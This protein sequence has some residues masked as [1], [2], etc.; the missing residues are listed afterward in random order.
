MT[1]VSMFCRKGH[2]H[3]A[4][5]DFYP[6][7]IMAKLKDLPIVR[8]RI[9]SV[10]QDPHCIR[11]PRGIP[12]SQSH[13]ALAAQWDWERNF[14]K[15]SDVTPG[16]DRE[17]H[18]IHDRCGQR[19][20]AAINSRVR[21]WD[22]GSA[23]QGCYICVGKTRGRSNKILKIPPWL[24]E[25]AVH[26]PRKLLACHLPA[27][28]LA[29]RLWKCPDENCGHIYCSRVCDRLDPESP[30]ERQGCP[31]EYHWKGGVDLRR[32]PDFLEMFVKTSINR[33][34]DP[35]RFPAQCKVRWQGKVCGH[36]FSAAFETVYEA[37]GC[38]T[39]L[40]RKKQAGF[41]VSDSRL[42]REFVRVPNFP[43]LT[44]ANI[45]RGSD[46]VAVWRG[47]CGHTFHYAIFRRTTDKQ[48][49]NICSGHRSE[50]DKFFSVYPRL[51]KFWDY[52]KNTFI[53]A[54]TGE[55]KPLEPDLIMA[56]E[57]K[58]HWLL[59]KRSGHS[60]RASLLDLLMKETACPKC[61]TLPNCV[62]V[63]APKLID[64]WCQRLN[65]DQTPWNKAAGSNEEVWWACPVHKSHVWEAQVK[66]RVHQSTGCPYCANRKVSVTN[67]LATKHPKIARHFHPEKNVDGQ[68]VLKAAEI[69]AATKKPIWWL[70][71][72]RESYQRFIK[73]MVD[74]GPGC[75][76]CKN[77]DRALAQASTK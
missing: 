59:C 62:A 27:R 64:Q 53:D 24:A 55:E 28:S 12:L 38:V 20:T 70:C 44:P 37:G 60:Y 35:H 23:N 30:T 48:N 77:S 66:K 54:T 50:G 22:E 72:C 34:F 10:G 16:S 15:P 69:I 57:R 49:C 47:A 17:V 32:H 14:Y 29:F 11:P 25:E 41:L 43:D 45:T 65:G 63:V 4:S 58:K 7:R 46:K 67:S 36:R 21:A 26:D 56:D 73:S 68:R 3:P 76:K 5:Q 33:G 74:F 13:P 61:K 42:T 71:H 6:H 40:N 52:E 18:W 31:S 39:C 19:I 9:R 1:L 2:E 8:G 75:A 51:L